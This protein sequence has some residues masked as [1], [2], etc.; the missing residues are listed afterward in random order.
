MRL[1]GRTFAFGLAVVLA[2]ATALADTVVTAREV[3][4][5]S[6][7]TADSSLV[8]LKLPGH[9]V[10]MFATSEVYELRLSD[11]ARVAEFSGRLPM[12]S[13]AP[14][15]G[16]PVPANEVRLEALRPRAPVAMLTEVQK[17]SLE[18]AGYKRGMSSAVFQVPL[19]A[20]GGVGLTSLGGCL[21]WGPGV[22][23]IA[24]G[25]GTAGCLGGACV[26]AMRPQ[27]P[28]GDTLAA[29]AYCAGIPEGSR[30]PAP[31]VSVP[32]LW[33]WLCLFSSS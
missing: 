15:S 1:R 12:L 6:I 7:E 10:R 26:G 22:V 30:Y 14:D 9:A 27:P 2:A 4:A 24:L 8:R 28:A 16:Q 19:A 20:G 25:A 18:H 5:G 21:F 31:A 32:A 3:V 23:P 33:Q 17:R 11:P 29:K 13:V